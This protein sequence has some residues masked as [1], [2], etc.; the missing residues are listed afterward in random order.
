MPRTFHA[1]ARINHVN[2]VTLADR[3]GGARRLARS[4]RNAV[5]G[6][7]HCHGRFSSNEFVVV[8][9]L[10]DKYTLAA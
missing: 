5:F 9:P 8:L 6:D 10:L 3:V 2:R 7:F 1:G 4:A